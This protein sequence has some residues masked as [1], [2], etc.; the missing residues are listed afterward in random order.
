M[1]VS[2]LDQT[3]DGRLGG[4][5]MLILNNQVCDTFNRI[6]WDAYEYTRVL[7]NSSFAVSS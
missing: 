1:L 3:D 7:S 4:N 2:S 5:F 6:Y